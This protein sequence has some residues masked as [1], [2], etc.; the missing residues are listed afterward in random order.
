MLF[1]HYIIKMFVCFLFFVEKS[2]E[3]EPNL[4]FWRRHCLPQTFM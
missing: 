1:S 3:A 4:D 2:Q